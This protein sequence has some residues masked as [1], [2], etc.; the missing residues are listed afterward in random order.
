MGVGSGCSWKNLRGYS[1]IPSLAA[2]RRVPS[3]CSSQQGR[4]GSPMARGRPQASKGRE[5]AS[6]HAAVHPCPAA[7]EVFLVGSSLK[8]RSAGKVMCLSWG[9]KSESGFPELNPS[10]R[11]SSA[12][13][14]LR[15]W[16]EWQVFL[17]FGFL[18]PIQDQ[19]SWPLEKL[20][21]HL[22]AALN[23]TSLQPAPG[24]A[25]LLG[26]ASMQSL[27]P[28]PFWSTISGR[29]D[30]QI[31]LYAVPGSAQHGLSGSTQPPLQNRLL[32]L[33]L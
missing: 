5:T 8:K 13:R 22:I 12:R 31:P 7:T 1:W 15:G 14:T 16:R 25:R 4:G 23:C 29:C 11:W 9:W 24:T 17:L 30:G 3:E 6:S 32:S 33:K 21:V 10:V 2:E 19:T 26:C 28:S 20:R 27:L 18:P